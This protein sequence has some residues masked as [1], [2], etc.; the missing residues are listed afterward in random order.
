VAVVNVLSFAYDHGILCAHTHFCMNTFLGRMLKNEEAP[1]ICSKLEM[2]TRG[3]RAPSW[4]GLPVPGVWSVEVS[5]SRGSSKTFRIDTKRMYSISGSGGGDIMVSDLRGR[6]RIFHHRDGLV[7]V[8]MEGGDAEI[9]SGMNRE[10]LTREPVPLGLGDSVQVEGDATIRL[11]RQSKVSVREALRS[12]QTE[13]EATRRNTALNGGKKMKRESPGPNITPLSGYR[14]R[15]KEP[16][17]Q[18]ENRVVKFLD[19]SND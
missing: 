3:S 19:F 4:C 16:K 13:D 12:T 2:D 5:T 10:R 18:D 6:V 9:I 8:N 7:Y 15:R 11:V 14:R 17:I 1:Q